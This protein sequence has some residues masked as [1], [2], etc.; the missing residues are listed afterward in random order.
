[1]SWRKQI[2]Q[3]SVQIKHAHHGEALILQLGTWGSSNGLTSVVFLLG[4]LWHFCFELIG[5]KT[6]NL[7]NQEIFKALFRDQILFLC[8]LSL[9]SWSLYVSANAHLSSRVIK[10]GNRLLFKWHYFHTTWCISPTIHYLM[11]MGYFHLHL[12]CLHVYM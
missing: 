10:V 2:N 4:F 5:R 7:F 1:M 12:L 3:Y 9:R 6:R 8:L 11:N